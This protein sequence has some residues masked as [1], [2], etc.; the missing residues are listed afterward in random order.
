MKAILIIADGLGGRPTDY[1]GK[2]CL[3]AAKTPYLDDL[4]ARGAVGLMDPIGPGICP[5]SDTA[6][7][8]ILGQNP[9]KVYTGRG[10]F[11][12][13]GIGMEMAPGD[14][15]FRANFATVEPTPEGLRVLDRRAGRISTGQKELEAAINSIKLNDVPD[16]DFEFRVSTQHRGALVLRGNGLCRYVSGT[17]PKQEGKIIGTSHPTVVG[18]IDAQRTAVALNELTKKSYEVL[19]D[20]PINH[21]R[22]DAGKSPANILLSRGAADLPVFQSLTSIYGVQGAVLALG[23]LYRGIGRALGMKMITLIDDTNSLDEDL[24]AIAKMAVA[25]LRE[26]DYLFI[27][28]K[29]PDNAAHDKDAIAK[30]A[31]I[32]RIDSELIA[33]LTSQV[34][35]KTTHLAFTGDHTT[36]IEYGDHTAEPVPIIFVGPNVLSDKVKEFHERAAAEGGLGR[37]SGQAL[38]ILFNYNNWA[39]KFGT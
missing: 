15:G 4:A 35:W 22:T 7:L 39:P 16:V 11:E 19:C 12:A 14:I 21:R 6:H 23:A 1:N 9:H 31:M 18:N 37:F 36:P 5:G 34:D 20:H 28:I 26:F 2:T 24:A 13:L 38:P 3:E 29:G 10:A 32:E 30:I 25:A 17:D 8:S 27:H 33:Y